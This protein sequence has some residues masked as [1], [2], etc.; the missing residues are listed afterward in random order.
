[1][2]TETK[3]LEQLRDF[4]KGSE[5]E[6]NQFMDRFRENFRFAIG[7]DNQWDPE[8]IAELNEDGRPH[9]SYNEILPKLNV[10]IGEFLD[11]AQQITVFARKGATVT[12]A[13]ILTAL[14]K[15]ATDLCNGEF[16]EADCFMNGLIGG[17][18][19]LG[20]EIDY[21]R[22][23]FNGD[24]IL[25]NKDPGDVIFDESNRKY[26]VNEGKFVFDMWWWDDDELALTYPKKAKD[27]RGGGLKGPASDSF[28]RQ[29]DW[30]PTVPDDDYG[31]PGESDLY[32]PDSDKVRKAKTRVRKC[33]WTSYEENKYLWDKAKPVELLKL[34]KKSLKIAQALMQ[35]NP[36]RYE[37]IERVGPTLH[38]TVQAGQL[39]LEDK[40]DPLGPRIT[41]FPLMRFCPYWFRGY[42]MGVVDNAK[43]PQTEL[44]KRLSQT[45]HILNIYAKGLWLNKRNEGADPDELRDES[46]KS[47][48]VIEYDTVK[49]EQDKRVPLPE[50]H[51]ALAAKNADA[52]GRVM[53]VREPM[54][55]GMEG[56]DQSGIAIQLRQN[57]GFKMSKPIFN[58]YRLTRQIAYEGL[59]ELIRYGDVYSQDEILEIIDEEDLMDKRMVAK[60]VKQLGQ[61]PQQP[62]PPDPAQMAALQEID[63]KRG[64]KGALAVT[65]EFKRAMDRYQQQMGQYQEQLKQMV[66]GM[67]TGEIKSLANG[68]YGTKVSQSPN[69]PTM[70]LAYFQMLLS[71]RQAGMAVPDDMIM[72]SSDHPQAEKIAD[73]MRQQPALPAGAA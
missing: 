18:G 58:R 64:T 17:E 52:I 23:P 26:D 36:D 56:K 46:T 33:W 72:E 61:P 19:V 20:W 40:D 8:A 48:G 41:R 30:Y 66:M 24:A 1:M 73:R 28:Y 6:H 62:Q 59:I 35:R 67:V 13:N 55:G 7:G 37:I 3:R 63:A 11:N 22:D 65:I 27:I 60:A 21:S 70:R 42:I 45:L 31:D 44:N 4:Y 71:M 29:Q 49:P 47:G 15:H 69:S 9:L 38:K 34:N 5:P 32:T 39:I 10:L 51:F 68:R 2:A 14:A 25:M 43:D 12:G 50:G 54:E 57:E 53:G 16:E